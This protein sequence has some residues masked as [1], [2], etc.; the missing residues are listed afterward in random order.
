MNMARTIAVASI[1]ALLAACGD[2]G[3]SA[4]TQGDSTTSGIAPAT[5]IDSDLTS[6]TGTG[7]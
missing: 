7:G 1:A 5:E 6:Q 2:G 4:G 3:N